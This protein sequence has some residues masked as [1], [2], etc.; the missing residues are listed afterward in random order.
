MY[1]ENDWMDV[2]GGFAAEQ[3]IKEERALALASA[4]EEEKKK[5]NGRARV[6]IIRNA[7]HHLYL[8]GW[9]EFNDVL[10]REMEETAREGRRAR[11]LI[12]KDKVQENAGDSSG[13]L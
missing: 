2:T 13:K 4:T 12:D 5:E 3:K 10:R 9:Q 8:D 1:G 6:V 11:A 7:G